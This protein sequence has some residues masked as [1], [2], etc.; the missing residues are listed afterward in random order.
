MHSEEKWMSIGASN[1]QVP[2][3]ARRQML[4]RLTNVKSGI[5][6]AAMWGAEPRDDSTSP[7]ALH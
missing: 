5:K 4:R 1:M 7:R 3:L 2:T 6:S